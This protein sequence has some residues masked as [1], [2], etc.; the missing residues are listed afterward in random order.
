VPI[1]G[2][3]F[4]PAEREAFER[5]AAAVRRVADELRG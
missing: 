3:D 4:A 5:S 2:L 1:G